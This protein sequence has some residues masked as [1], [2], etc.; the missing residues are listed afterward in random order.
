MI[1]WCLYQSIEQ[2]VTSE[3]TFW[4]S[5]TA[6]IITIL[7][8]EHKDN[9]QPKWQTVFLSKHSTFKWKYRNE[10]CIIIHVCESKERQNRTKRSNIQWKANLIIN[11]IHQLKLAM[12][13]P[14]LSAG[15]A[16]SSERKLI[17][18]APW[19]CSKSF[20]L[21]RGSWISSRPHR[22]K[23]LPSVG[24]SFRLVS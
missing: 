20:R 17:T 14:L 1:F 21:C 15:A 13:W 6:L 16:L 22:Y 2:P 23:E 12:T 7:F 9:W 19:R 24:P 10:R 3:G 18:V 8:N 5:Q 4:P 11:Y